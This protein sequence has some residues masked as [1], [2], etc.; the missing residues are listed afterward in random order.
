MAFFCVDAQASLINHFR[1]LDYEVFYIYRDSKVNIELVWS[2]KDKLYNSVTTSSSGCRL[3]HNQPFQYTVKSKV[4]FDKSSKWEMET[5]LSYGAWK[6]FF[7]Y[8]THIPLE[9]SISQFQ[10]FMPTEICNFPEWDVILLGV[11]NV[12][13]V[14]LYLIL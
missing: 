1:L 7:T 9:L 13:T 2:E 4:R 6:T 12:T 8:V 3:Q 5:E 14:D 11:E 10:N